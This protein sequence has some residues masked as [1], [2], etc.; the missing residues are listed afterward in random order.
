VGFNVLLQRGWADLHRWLRQIASTDRN[1]G[2]TAVNEI[3]DDCTKQSRNTKINKSC[4]S[5]D[6]KTTSKLDVEGRTILK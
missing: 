4:E 2:Q 6:K 5:E 3:G 1:I